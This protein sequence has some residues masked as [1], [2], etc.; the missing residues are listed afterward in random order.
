M[1]RKRER[2]LTR[3]RGDRKAFEVDYLD[4]AGKRHRPL[5]E[6]E[7]QAKAFAAQIVKDLN[8]GILP[9][10]TSTLTLREFA[11]QRFEVWKAQLAPRTWRSHTGRLTRHVL[12]ALGDL[13]VRAIRPS[14]CVALFEKLQVRRLAPTTLRMI[15]SNLVTLLDD[16]VRAEV[17]DHNPAHRLAVRGLRRADANGDTIRPFAREE[18]DRFLATAAEAPDRRWFALFSVLCYAGLRPEEAYALKVI[19]VD[20]HDKRLRVVR[21]LNEDRTLK[22]PKTFTGRRDVDLCADLVAVLKAYLPWRAA[23]VLQRGWGSDCDWLFPNDDDRPLAERYVRKVFRRILKQAALA[24]HTPADGRHTFAT[25][26]LLAGE[27]SLYVAAQLG[28]T[29]PATTFRFYAHWIPDRGQRGVEALNRE[30]ESMAGGTERR[31]R[32]Q[33]R[34]QTAFLPRQT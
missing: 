31:V 5:F 1:K 12:P 16:A 8:Q 13:K 17:I 25:L 11:G 24:D 2:V 15:R 33:I 27:P 7:E 14:H 23:Y 32:N 29:S 30:R 3:Y 18:R 9:A 21:A 6:T 28:H 26:L 34:N 19:D 22:S 20:F 4:L 10:D